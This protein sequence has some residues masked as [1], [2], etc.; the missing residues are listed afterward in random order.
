MPRARP[1]TCRERSGE[2]RLA[3]RADV[4]DLAA[5]ELETLGFVARQLHRERLAVLAHEL[6]ADLEPEAD[7]PLDHRLARRSVRLEDELEVVR[8]HERVAEAVRLPDERHHELV[9]RTLV[10]LDGPGDL[11][12]PALVHHDD[13]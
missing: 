9:R 5:V 4:D 8:P 12:D 10:E 7:D 11:L 1:R 6:D 2:G 3:R 13:L